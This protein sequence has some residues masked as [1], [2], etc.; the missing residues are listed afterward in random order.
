MLFVEPLRS[1]AR[2]RQ[3]GSCCRDVK[4]AQRL[5]HHIPLTRQ[6]AL[7]LFHALNTVFFTVSSQRAEL[8]STLETC[9]ETIEKHVMT[10]TCSLEMAIY[11][12]VLQKVHLAEQQE[13][14]RHA[15]CDR[16]PIFVCRYFLQ[17]IS[18]LLA[19]CNV[20]S[21]QTDLKTYNAGRYKR[22]GFALFYTAKL[23]TKGVEKLNLAGTAIGKKC[24]IV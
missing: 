24:Y 14:C 5:Q 8:G 12:S 11:M 20:K 16:Q 15:C 9:S 22:T 19:V 21:C 17:C 4:F 1:P 2:T 18:D 10:H 13:T 23:C 3:P 7:K 6:E